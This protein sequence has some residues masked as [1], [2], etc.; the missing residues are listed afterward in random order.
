MLSSVSGGLSGAGYNGQGALGL[1]YYSSGNNVA[2]TALS[3]ENRGIPFRWNKISSNWHTVALSGNTVFRTGYNSSYQ[4][5]DGAGLGNRN[6]FLQLSGYWSDIATSFDN[7]YLLS[8]GTYTWY[9][10]GSNGQGQLGQGPGAYATTRFSYLTAI[11]GNWERLIAAPGNSVGYGAGSVYGLS[12]GTQYKW[13]SFGGNDFGQLGQGFNPSIVSAISRM[14]PI[15][16]RW[17]NIVAGLNTS[18]ALSADPDSTG[19]YRWHCCGKDD[20]GQLGR[21]NNYAGTT[22]TFERYITTFVPMTGNW[23]KIVPGQTYTF[24]KS[25]GTNKWFGGGWNNGGSLSLGSS[26]YNTS[27]A[28][29]QPISGTYDDIFALFST[30]IALTS[31]TT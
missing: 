26:V 27:G 14:W 5:G 29:F 4:L 7:T 23:S 22:F 6:S 11:S 28:P 20:Y 9:A 31:Y 12:A 10:V 30:T 21:S 19:V 3:A 13:S 18:F 16:G 25:A 24:A 17:S 1:G 8:A 15:T 2:L